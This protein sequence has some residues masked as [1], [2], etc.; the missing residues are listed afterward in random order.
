MLMY[1]AWAETQ[2]YSTGQ[3]S[4]HTYTINLLLYIYNREDVKSVYLSLP[5]R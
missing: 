3:L 5:T 2:Y 4:K 1:E